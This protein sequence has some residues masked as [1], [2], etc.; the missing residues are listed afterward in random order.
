MAGNESPAEEEAQAVEQPEP[1]VSFATNQQPEVRTRPGINFIDIVLAAIL[2]VSV[3]AVVVI[4]G[5]QIFATIRNIVG[6]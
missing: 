3:V 1:A 2:F 5:W 4:L 6:F